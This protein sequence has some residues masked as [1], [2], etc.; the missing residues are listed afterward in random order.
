[1]TDSWVYCYGLFFSRNAERDGRREP[2]GGI[3]MNARTPGRRRRR[4]FVA[5]RDN[6]GVIRAPYRR[7]VI[8]AICSREI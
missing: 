1:M 7:N 6:Y 8:D 3:P 5:F 2:R 4:K